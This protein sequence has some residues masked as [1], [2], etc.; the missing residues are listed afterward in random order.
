MRRACPWEEA[1][2]RPGVEVRLTLLPDECGGAVLERRPERCWIL[3][4][5]RR[6]P[7]EQRC[8]L[9]HELTHLDRGSMRCDASPATW[10]PVVAREEDAVNAEVADWLVGP[11][12]LWTLVGDMVAEERDVTTREI[13]EHYQVTRDVARTALARLAR[14]QGQV[15]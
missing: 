3:L 6:S 15:A 9:A 8:L 2:R 1:D 5:L 12:D 10:G 14:R 11:F 7:V 13:A 4:D